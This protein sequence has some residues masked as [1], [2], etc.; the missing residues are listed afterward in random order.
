MNVAGIDLNLLTA[1]DALVKYGAVTTAAARIGRSQPAM[2]HALRRLR[3]LFD[4]EL[5]VR[6]PD[7]MEPTARARALADCLTPA[8]EQIRRAIDPRGEFAPGAS[9]RVFTVGM[10][11]YA[12]IALIGPLT[13]AVR[14]R[15]PRIDLRVVPVS[16]ADY[17][18]RLD[19]GTL[20]V[21]IGNLNDAPPRFARTLLFEDP[22][23]CVAR[24]G[25]PAFARTLSL[26][27]YVRQLHVLVSP[28]GEAH[29]PID[30]L[31]AARGHQRRIAV[32]V[33]TYLA[34]PL[35]LGSSDLIA[36]M[37]AHPARTLETLAGLALR[38][39]PLQEVAEVAMLWHRRDDG[40]PGHAWLRGVLAEV[41]RSSTHQAPP[42]QPKRTEAKKRR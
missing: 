18:A 14:A 17:I 26:G 6:T 7:G 38:R 37:P 8:L 21:A 11:E 28:I 13:R 35:V 4:D 19:G 24:A 3:E 36:T 33:G 16:R 34:V 31:L 12:E 20:D 29:G 22:L 15:A 9:D 39:L 2:S 41:S 23:V 5:F 42:G 27:A 40:D 30:R 10:S 1:F 25:H 32:V